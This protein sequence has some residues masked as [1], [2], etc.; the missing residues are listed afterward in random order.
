MPPAAESVPALVAA[1]RRGGPEAIAAL[2]RRVPVFADAIGGRGPFAVHQGWGVAHPGP[3]SLRDVTELA[4]YL[5]RDTAVR[6][7]LL[8]ANRNEHQLLVMAALDGGM[9]DKFATRALLGLAGDRSGQARLD[10]AAAGLNDL[11]LTDSSAGWVALVPA[12]IDWIPRPGIT[13]R[14]GSEGINRDA[15]SPPAS[16]ACN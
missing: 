8:H 5:S 7:R 4:N 13:F 10:R 2:I 6:L 11:L 1:L 14:S 15:C 16:S 12:I 3:Q 9:L